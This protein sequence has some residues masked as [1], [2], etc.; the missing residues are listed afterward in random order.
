M[1]NS[2]VHHLSKSEEKMKSSNGNTSN[3][4][5]S[6]CN[7]SN[8]NNLNPSHPNSGFAIDSHTLFEIL[9][10]T[11]MIMFK[12]NNSNYIEL[13]K[14]YLK[15]RTQEESFSEDEL[16]KYQ[17]VLL[18]I[19]RWLHL[20]EKIK[21]EYQFDSVYFKN[22]RYS[23]FIVFEQKDQLIN[24]IS[25]VSAS[26]SNSRYPVIQKNLLVLF[27]PQ[28]K[29]TYLIYTN[30]LI[31]NGFWSLDS[32]NEREI[33]KVRP[34]EIISNFSSYENRMDTHGTIKLK[35][36]PK[37]FFEI[38]LDKNKDDNNNNNDNNENFY[39]CC[40]SFLRRCL[41]EK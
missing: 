24:I 33:R 32:I 17:G 40:T 30:N 27:S 29:I 31:F 21:W 37:N 35:E 34:S 10:Q 20:I 5:T 19:R 8:D 11:F 13:A 36:S 41:D 7:I 23:V 16:G 14:K 22:A 1:N 3:C 25:N 9:S 18:E 15:V 6:N 28:T 39:M 26:A 4:N 2:K 38:N 12:S